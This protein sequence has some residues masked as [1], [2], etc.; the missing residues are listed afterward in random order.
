ML[1]VFDIVQPLDKS[2]TGIIT[3]TDGKDANVE[4]FGEFDS[5]TNLYNAWWEESELN[6]VDNLI[7]VIANSLANGCGTNT[8]QG[9]KLLQKIRKPKRK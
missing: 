6:V 3:E 9:D 8:E 4:W 2:A 5:D 1:N 7:R